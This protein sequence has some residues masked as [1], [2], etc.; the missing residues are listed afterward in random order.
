MKRVFDTNSRRYTISSGTKGVVSLQHNVQDGSLVKEGSL[1]IDN[2]SIPQQ[3][4]QSSAEATL[5]LRMPNGVKTSIADPQLTG[6]FF[7]ADST[8]SFLMLIS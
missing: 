6:S 2:M 1:A 3:Y 4:R 8:V 5:S 7:A